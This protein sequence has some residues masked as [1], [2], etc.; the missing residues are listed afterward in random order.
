MGSGKSKM[1]DRKSVFENPL[2]ETL[3]DTDLNQLFPPET[4]LEDLENRWKNSKP[5]P[6][7]F[8]KL[9][10]ALT[11]LKTTKSPRQISEI[12]LTYPQVYQMW[13]NVLE[14]K[15]FKNTNKSDPLY[16]FKQQKANRASLTLGKLGYVPS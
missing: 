8:K 10:D 3:T 6:A 16:R 1:V 9:E 5:L 11:R 15:K 7:D 13:S 2:V 14:I 12:I 4:M